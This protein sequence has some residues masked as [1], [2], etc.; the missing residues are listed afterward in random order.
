MSSKGRTKSYCPFP[1]YAIKY[2]VALNTYLKESAIQ[3]DTMK[4]QVMALHKY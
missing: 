1:L 3:L 4:I 2:R